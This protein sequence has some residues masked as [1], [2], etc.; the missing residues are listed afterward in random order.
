M[1]NKVILLCVVIRDQPIMLLYL[2][3]FYATVSL[4]F[5]YYA[6]YYAQ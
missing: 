2:S 6:Q 3:I 5:T 4:K 1:V